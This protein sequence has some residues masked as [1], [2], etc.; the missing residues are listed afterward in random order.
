MFVIIGS[1]VKLLKLWTVYHRYLTV[2]TTRSFKCRVLIYSH[3]TDDNEVET[4]IS[5]DRPME[6]QTSLIDCVHRVVRVFIVWFPVCSLSFVTR[7]GS[8]TIGSDRLWVSLL[9]AIAGAEHFFYRVSSGEC[10]FL[11]R[12]AAWELWVSE[13]FKK[14][15]KSGHLSH[16]LASGV[17]FFVFFWVSTISGSKRELVV[18]WA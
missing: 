7:R 14:H 12:Y 17:P 3:Q 10:L 11:I 6:L 15:K 9:W 8:D 1:G 2:P 16:Y 18:S 13:G 4:I 5:T